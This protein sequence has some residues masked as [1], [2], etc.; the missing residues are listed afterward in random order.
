[1]RALILG[2][3]G[4]TGPAV[5]KGLLKRGYDV[6]VMHSGSHEA[7]LA[8]EVEHLHGDVHFP[9]T[10]AATLGRRSFDLVVAQYGRLKVTADFMRDRTPRVI[11]IG[12]IWRSTGRD[13]MWGHLGRP[14]MTDEG[15]PPPPVDAGGLQPKIHAA[16]QRVF[17]NHAE[18]YYQATYI[19]HSETYG[20][21]QHAPWQWSVIKRVLDGRRVFLLPDSG[22]RIRQRTYGPNAA[23]ATLLCIDQPQLASGQKFHVG[24]W[25]L[26]TERQRIQLI[27]KTLGVDLEFLD[28]PY[29]A[30]GPAQYYWRGGPSH[31]V[32]DDSKIRRLL[33]YHESTPPDT[34]EI[35]T[36]RWIV[37]NHHALSEEWERQ[38]QDMFD[39]SAEDRA[40]DVWAG[41]R[42]S[43]ARIGVE[44]NPPSHAY[45]HPRKPGER[46][47]R[48]SVTGAYDREQD[49]LATEYY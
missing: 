1:M 43:M 7:D 4:P 12:S 33:G 6:T 46:W 20:P 9:E 25:P 21:R 10:L 11:A 30:A 16:M 38:M 19:G 31:Q 41:A 8:A 2:G 17:D 26:Y 18:G 32:R 45:L 44:H 22:L 28:V 39:Y 5:V 27:A 14:L 42:A 13:P 15:V 48:S 24:E 35:E 3:T 23:E 34:A 37:D 49:H 47:S 29:G 36:V 40:I